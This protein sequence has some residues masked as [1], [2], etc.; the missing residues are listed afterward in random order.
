MAEPTPRASVSS[1]YPLFLAYA[2]VVLSLWRV[3][4]GIVG[5]QFLTPSPGGNNAETNL[6]PFDPRHDSGSRLRASSVEQFAVSSSGGVRTE[7]ENDEVL[8]KATVALMVYATGDGIR[9]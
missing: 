4:T 9:R 6:A 8:R 2:L 3:D 7:A 5:Q 1:A